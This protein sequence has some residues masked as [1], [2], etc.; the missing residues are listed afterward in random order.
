MAS[1]LITTVDVS[2]ING[3]VT[4]DKAIKSQNADD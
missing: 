2:L 1:A 4:Y 3:L